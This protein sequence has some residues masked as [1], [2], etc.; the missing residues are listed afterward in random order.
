MNRSV[1][2]SFKSRIQSISSARRVPARELWETLVL[3]RFLVRVSLSSHADKFI[4]K[5]G[6][7]LSRYV[8][9]GR[10]TQDLGFLIRWMSTDPQ[11]LLKT[12]EEILAVP[13]EDG[14]HFFEP[15]IK[16][17]SHPHMKYPGARVAM[18]ALFGK[19][20][21]K[22]I[23]DLG[24]GDFVE[25]MT[26]TLPLLSTDKGPLFES[27]VEMVC[28]PEEFIFAEK[29]EAVVYLESKNSRMKDFHDL[30]LLAR[31]G[32]CRGSNLERVIRLVF[33]H[34]ETPI[35][36]P[37]KFSPTEFERL[38]SFWVRHLNSGL[39]DNIRLPLKFDHLII[40]LNLWL[41][42]QTSLCHE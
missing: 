42:E 11:R 13:I 18:R 34:R 4:F 9:I 29:L 20:R 39:S 30:C 17:L 10:H 32:S 2:Q 6:A 28:Y 21:F 3:E 12:V 15:V 33:E 8:E 1:E 41:K 16:P 36:L 25:P 40:E 14:F 27:H 23:V 31:G 7:L 19:T 35:R 26:R 24:C 37:L 22:V 38:Q 5:G